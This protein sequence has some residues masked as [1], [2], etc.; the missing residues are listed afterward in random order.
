MYKHP[1]RLLCALILFVAFLPSMQAGDD[2]SGKTPCSV[3]LSRPFTTYAMTPKDKEWSRRLTKKFRYAGPVVHFVQTSLPLKVGNRLVEG[4]V[5]QSIEKR[6]FFYVV[7]GDVMLRLG[8]QW[9]YNPG[10]GGFSMHAPKSRKFIVSLNFVEGGVPFL[11]SSIVKKG[12]VYWD[13][14]PEWNRLR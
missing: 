3:D 4:A 13:G 5:Y 1:K 9:A 12:I 7:D 10:V 6:D 14:D 8:K 11:S 2:A